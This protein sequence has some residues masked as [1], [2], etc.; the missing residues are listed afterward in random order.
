MAASESSRAGSV[1]DAPSDLRPAL[2]TQRHRDLIDRLDLIAREI[3]ASNHL[4]RRILGQGAA[5]QMR[6]AANPAAPAS[7]DRGRHTAEH[8]RDPG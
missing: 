2:E 5:T 1:P 4:L 7:S 8:E 3:E 6:G